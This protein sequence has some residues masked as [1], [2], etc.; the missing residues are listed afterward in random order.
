MSGR[1]G[2]AAPCT[3]SRRDS[4]QTC[5]RKSL[6]TDAQLLQQVT[7]RWADPQ[8]A[9]VRRRTRATC[10]MPRAPSFRLTTRAGTG[11]PHSAAST[12]LAPAIAAWLQLQPPV[13]VAG[14]LGSTQGAC[15]HLANSKRACARWLAVPLSAASLRSGPELRRATP[16]PLLAGPET[17]KRAPARPV[18]LFDCAATA[19]GADF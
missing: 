7:R 12:T 8:P 1:R 16:R 6:L 11:R 2:R 9:A 15:A 17:P 10:S 13:R 14:R 5:H 18:R 19:R 3:A 4:S